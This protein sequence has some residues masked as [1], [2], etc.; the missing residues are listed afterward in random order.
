V[1]LGFC[2]RAHV[3]RGF[4]ADHRC[5]ERLRQQRREPPGAAAEVDRQADRLRGT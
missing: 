4:D 1:G 3:R 5:G 2:R